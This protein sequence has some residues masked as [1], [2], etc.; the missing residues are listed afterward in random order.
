MRASSLNLVHAPADNQAV[1]VNVW[2]PAP[3]PLPSVWLDGQAVMLSARSTGSLPVIFAEL[4]S[5]AASRQ[6]VLSGVWVDGTPAEQLA[7]QKTGRQFQRVEAESISLAELSRRLVEETR[8]QVRELRWGVEQAV[9]TVLINEPPQ[10][11]R[12]WQRWRAAIRE[13]LAKLGMLR[14]L[15]GARLG[16]LSAGGHS[17]EAHLEELGRIAGHVELIL[18]KP[19]ADSLP[20][21]VILS[22][23]FERNLAPWLRRLEDYLGQLHEQTLE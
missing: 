16:E 17:L 1:S 23:V 14:E 19:D 9:L 5:L 20:A 10:N 21:A 2:K 15:W 6:R 7:G 12:L 18:L 4:E 13:V 8:G 11:R 3:L 22:N